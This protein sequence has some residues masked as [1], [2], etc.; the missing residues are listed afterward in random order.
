MEVYDYDILV[1]LNKKSFKIRAQETSP[2]SRATPMP[3][4]VIPLN[5]APSKT[6][7]PNT[8]ALPILLLIFKSQMW[9][10]YV[11][12][13]SQYRRSQTQFFYQTDRN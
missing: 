8:A 12:Y 13:D 3:Y 7:P 6:A 2:D 9:I 5:T 11:I 1:I 10:L 4:T